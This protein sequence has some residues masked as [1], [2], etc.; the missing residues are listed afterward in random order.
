MPSLQAFTNF[1]L[2]TGNKLKTGPDEIIN[3]AT[4]NT[5]IINRCL[6]GMGAADAVQS[7]QRIIDRILLNDVGTAQFYSPNDPMSIQNVS[8]LK[9]IRIDWRFFA[10]HY[11]YTQQEVVLNSGDPQ[12]YYKNL[13]KA[14]RQQCVTSSFNKMEDAIWDT[15]NSAT[16]EAQNGTV[17][18]SIP[19][20][21]TENTSGLP[22]GFTTVMG[23]PVTGNT[24]WD[25][26][27]ET[28]DPTDLLN[29]DTGLVQA[30]DEMFMKVRFRPPRNEREYFENDELQQMMIATNRNGRS[31]YLRLTRDSNDRLVGNDLGAQQSGLGYAGLPVEYIATLDNAGWTD[32]QPRYYFLNLKYLHPVWHSTEYMKEMA[33]M[34][35]PN[36]PFSWVVWKS[37]YYNWFCQS[38]RRQGI[39]YPS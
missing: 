21:V 36:Q 17:P 15:P 2:A 25:N 16:M 10:D 23:L 35:D 8:A 19:C 3:D 39:I 20:F 14:K 37:T 5:Y 28:Y 18:Y 6:K 12:T 22:T 27:R 31:I 30:F 32:G 4:K 24:N 34:N 1:V 7:G 9:E 11:S 26:Q 13:L 33:P 29:P 38:R